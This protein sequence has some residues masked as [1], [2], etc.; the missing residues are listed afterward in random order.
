[1]TNIILGLG[2]EILCDDAIG[3]RL[4][5]RLADDCASPGGPNLPGW[6][7]TWGELGPLET[8]E[9]LTGHD[10]AII[11]DAMKSPDRAPGEIEVFSIDDL[12]GVVHLGWYHGMNLQTA[13]QFLEDQGARLP[14]RLA[15]IG[16]TIVD[17]MLLS[18][19]MTPELE[20]GFEEVYT[21]VVETVRG[22]VGEM[23]GRRGAE[24]PQ[25]D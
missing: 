22:L 23:G 15:I 7:V 12:E 9:R 1:M 6:E 2:N 8:A 11:L 14:T 4:A 10:A 3:I 25:H 19:R 21:K 13:M 18:E 17:N 16:I 20:E 24:E 5:R